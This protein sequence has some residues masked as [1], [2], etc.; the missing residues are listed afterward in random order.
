MWDR[1]T[2]RREREIAAQQT[3]VQREIADNR[4]RARHPEVWAQIQNERA[5]AA[6]RAFERNNRWAALKLVLSVGFFLALFLAAY[7]TSEDKPA[8]L[9]TSP[10]D[11]SGAPPAVKLPAPRGPTIL[12]ASLLY[13]LTEDTDV[14]AEPNTSSRIVGRVHA[15]HSLHVTGR[16]DDDSYLRIQ[17]RDGTIGFVHS[18]VAQYIAVWQ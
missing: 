1:R 11:V 18:S 10:S 2:A 13:R 3:A 12:E 6:A 9:A 15:G 17:M 14:Y 4:L 5:A 8:P 16:T 7:F